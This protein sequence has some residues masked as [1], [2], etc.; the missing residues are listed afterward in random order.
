VGFAIELAHVNLLPDISSSLR[1]KLSITLLNK[2]GQP[3][4]K[5]SLFFSLGV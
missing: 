2:K 5:L 4:L 1:F 3:E